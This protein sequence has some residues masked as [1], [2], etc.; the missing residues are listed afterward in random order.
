MALRIGGSS[1]ILMIATVL[2]LGCTDSSKTQPTLGTSSSTS[3]GNEEREE[4][5]VCDGDDLNDKTCEDLGYDDGELACADNCRAFDRSDC[6][7]DE[8]C[9]DDDAAGPEAC[10][11]EDLDGETCE[12]L[13][14][15]GGEL[16]CADDCLDFDTDDCI[17]GPECGDGVAEADEVCDGEDLDGETC[18]SLGFEGGALRCADNCLEFDTNDCIAAEG[19]GDGVVSGDE[20]CDGTNLDGESCENLGFEGGTLRCTR[21]CRAFDTADC[22]GTSCGNGEI[23]EGEVCD[24]DDLDGQGCVSLGYDG[25]TLA[26]APS[27]LAFRTSGCFEVECGDD[28]VQGDEMCDG[29]DLDGETCESLG[30]DTG[31]LACAESCAAF[32]TSDCSNYR[33]GN[34]ILEGDEVC[35]GTAL[36]GETCESLGFD[37]GTLHCNAGCSAFDTSVCEE[38]ISLCGD[39]VTQ[40]YE[41]CDGESDS[42]GDLIEGLGSGI[43]TCTEDCTLDTSGCESPDLCAAAGW[44]DDGTCDACELVGGTE[45]PDCEGCVEDGECADYFDSS[46]GVWG[47]VYAGFGHDP[48]CTCGNGA[49]GPNEHCDGSDIDPDDSCQD[50]GFSSGTLGCTD[51]C[52]LDFSDC[53]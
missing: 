17:G 12:S 3:C 13:G 26:C 32:D 29:D 14:F 7:T 15:D 27:C 41:A 6:V 1:R 5:E 2:L 42:C 36:D 38:V 34:N 4:N 25:G 11:G 48:D 30:F 24:D 39:G 50:Y 47:C 28:E 23:D 53:E 22:L 46:Y 8:E 45:D 49:R 33:C 21:S 9:G 20:V 40:G 44:Y 52:L 51:E 31:I 16:H 10:D 18:E 43:A 19:C 37:D 35:D